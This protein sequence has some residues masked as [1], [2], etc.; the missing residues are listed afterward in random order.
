M[1]MFPEGRH[2]WGIMDSFSYAEEVKTLVLKWLKQS[3][4]LVGEKK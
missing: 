4:I 3:E 1:Y 2:G